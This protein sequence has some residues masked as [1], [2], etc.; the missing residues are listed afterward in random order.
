MKKEFV[1]KLTKEQ[2][3]ILRDKHTEFPFTGKLLHNT[4]QGVYTC[5][6]C[7]NVLFRSE[8]KY[9][10][11]SGWPSFYDL[12]KKGSVT[13]KPAHHW[14]IKQWEVLCSKCGGHLGHMYLD[15]PRDKTGKRY[16]INSRVLDFKEK[17]KK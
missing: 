7:G 4:K 6:A 5:A 11:F 16:C 12:A 8:H 10:S 15:G 17:M 1:N 2:V 9:N 3:H 14:M 13:L